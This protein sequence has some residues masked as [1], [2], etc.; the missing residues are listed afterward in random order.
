VIVHTWGR[1]ASC[2][3]AEQR[4]CSS[5]AEIAD[6]VR[7]AA[8][9]GRKVK[10][11]GAGHSWSDCAMTDGVLVRV[12][13]LS[14]V[15]VDKQRGLVRVGAGLPLRALNDALAAEGLA[16]PIVG[17]IAAQSI[18]GVVSTGTHGSSLRHGNLSTGV[19]GLRI[20]N[21]RGEV[22]ALE[23]SDPRLP[24]ARVAL[25]ALGIVTEVTLRV[26]PAFKVVQEME[27]VDFDRAVAALPALPHEAEYG[28]LWWFPHTNRALVFR[29]RRT[30][31]PPTFSEQARALDERL[32]N[33]IVFAGLLGL[34][35]RAPALI[36]A[37]NRMIA[38]SYATPR[39]VVG[40]SDHVLSL[41][42][43]PRH[44]ECEWAVPVDAGPALVRATR[45]LIERRGFR[46]NFI[47]EARFVRGDDTWLSPAYGQDVMQIGAYS[48][49]PGDH[50]A[51][52]DAFA[53]IAREMGGRPHWGKEASFTPMDVA[54]WYPELPRFRA[55]AR[56]LDPDGVFRTPFV[57]RVLGAD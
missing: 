42:M 2:T 40:R 38:L 22:V 32:L 53:A 11:I 19:V 50:E 15:R 20:V 30:T 31:E 13:G 34:G 6:V 37:L 23:D 47:F 14:S 48:A 16:L 24:G 54:G 57:E 39:R 36:P 43:P 26:G 49:N 46:V 25:G 18:A 27:P 51:F 1:S 9:A 17:S 21:G 44:R 5:E 41:A 56:D 28:K 29:G 12:D 3:P 35:A 52:F 10:A 45:D 4:V 33:G 7:A 55:L 8:Q